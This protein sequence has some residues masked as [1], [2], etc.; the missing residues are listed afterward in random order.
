MSA[1][2]GLPVFTVSVLAPTS[3]GVP[4]APML[5]VPEIRLMV[6]DERMVL[7][8]RVMEPEPLAVI[9]KMP[10]APVEAS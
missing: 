4:E 6:P 7:P 9:F 10:D 2:P 8:L 3:S 5:P 1:V